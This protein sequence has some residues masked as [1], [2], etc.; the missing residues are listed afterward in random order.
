[1]TRLRAFAL[2]WYGFIVGDDLRLA[3]GLLAAL[4]LTWL[5][6][7]SEVPAWWLIPA[8]VAVLLTESL[9]RATR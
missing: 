2:F 1:V 9:R 8:A 3:L 4:L 5:L 6:A 7:R